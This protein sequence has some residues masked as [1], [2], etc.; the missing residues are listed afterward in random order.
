MKALACALVVAAASPA[1]AQSV[2]AWSLGSRSWDGL[3]TLAQTAGELGCTIEPR[4]ELALD[5][6]DRKDTVWMLHPTRRLHAAEWLRFV[7]NGGALVVLDDFGEAGPLLS[8]FGLSRA[9]VVAARTLDNNPHLPI[10]EPTGQGSVTS[11]QP[12][13]ANHPTALRGDHPA[14]FQ[15]SGRSGLVFELRLG[16]GTALLGGDPSLVINNMLELA[17]N[18]EFARALIRATC[19]AR[20]GHVF[21][22]VDDFVAAGQIRL[23][24]SP[25]LPLVAQ[26]RS[27]AAELNARAAA[28]ATQSLPVQLDVRVAAGLA[29]CLLLVGLSG[30]L[31]QVGRPTV[32]DAEFFRASHATKG[33]PALL[34]L[35]RHRIDDWWQTEGRTASAAQ[36]RFAHELHER[37]LQLEIQGTFSDAQLSEVHAQYKRLLGQR[38]DEA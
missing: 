9:E 16:E 3:A 36:K 11:D 37:I 6:L 26:A 25:R 12:I 30:L 33:P 18:L 4:T 19:T 29:L 21:L 14:T 1:A 31:G 23:P 13:V 20:S 35:M 5:R 2:S 34:E 7:E 32:F 17:G 27:V 24:A 15:F 28:L 38:E 8:R 10:A 22:L